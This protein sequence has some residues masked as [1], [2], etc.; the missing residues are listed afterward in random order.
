MRLR[1]A[2]PLHS[3]SDGKEY[4]FNELNG[5]TSWTIPTASEQPKPAGTTDPAAAGD[6]SE[7]APS[8]PASMTINVPD[9]GAGNGRG[10]S[11]SMP[12]LSGLAG[13]MGERGLQRVLVITVCSVVVIIQASIFLDRTLGDGG[14]EAYGVAVGSVSLGF[15][16]VTLLIAKKYPSTFSEWSVP[17]VRGELTSSRETQASES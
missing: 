3:D 15:S 14:P 1:T 10:R 2:C 6:N 11:S 17:K 4:Y 16:V 13:L 12:D 8:N 7:F 9:Y 5:E